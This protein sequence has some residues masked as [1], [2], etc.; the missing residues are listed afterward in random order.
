MS[1]PDQ[2]ASGTGA[3]KSPDA[4]A[5]ARPSYADAVRTTVAPTPKRPAAGQ[6][7]AQPAGCISFLQ[8]GACT[9]EPCKLVHSRTACSCTNVTCKK[10]H[11]HATPTKDAA[12][13]LA[14]A[15]IPAAGAITPADPPRLTPATFAHLQH[16]AAQFSHRF[17][18]YCSTFIP[19][20]WN[21]DNATTQVHKTSKI[22]FDA[23]L[24]G[25]PEDKL[26]AIG[27]LAER[28][29]P[30][31]V[32]YDAHVETCRS[33]MYST[34]LASTSQL[35]AAALDATLMF[36]AEVRCQFAE[37]KAN[38]ERRLKASE[39]MV[40]YRLLERT[41]TTSLLTAPPAKEANRRRSRTKE[42]APP[43]IVAARPLLR[44]PHERARKPP[45]PPTAAPKR[46]K[47]TAAATD[48]AASA[49]S[50]DRPAAT[51]KT[52]GPPTAHI[53][54]ATDAAPTTPAAAATKKK[55]GPVAAPAALPEDAAARQ[56]PALGSRAGATPSAVA[57]KRAAKTT[58]PAAAPAGL[59]EDAAKQLPVSAGPESAAATRELP[60]LG[61]QT[62]CF[63][64]PQETTTTAGAAA[65]DHDAA[66]ALANRGA[67]KVTVQ[68]P[69]DLGISEATDD[70]AVTERR[71]H[72]Q[73]L[74]DARSTRHG[75]KKE[76]HV[77]K[78]GTDSRLA[79]A[80]SIRATATQQRLEAVRTA[81]AADS[82]PTS[83]PP[84]AADICDDTPL[85]PTQRES[86]ADTQ[87][88][89]TTTS[90]A[91]HP[92]TLGL[93]LATAMVT[94]VVAATF[95]AQPADAWLLPTPCLSGLVNTTWPTAN[96]TPLHWALPP[97]A[98]VLDA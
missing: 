59:P 26:P 13:A 61:Q 1:Q 68:P 41:T 84:S 9:R 76:T 88:A 31:P 6:V 56:P 75:V 64:L 42:H 17:C 32:T 23:V 73:L 7:T 43:T 40:A 2:P 82:P 86:G 53:D 55:T 4:A 50:A 54:A 22:F 10:F 47:K 20:E 63:P 52:K 25:T 24:S 95:A 30:I 70:S 67:R 46:G 12:K 80:A 58:A 74:S 51:K 27:E 39:D 16:V 79:Q 44:A 78:A 85:L 36:L 87:V 62:D 8:T 69:L 49:P 45:P 83:V 94:T 5:S 72:P 11:W 93:R 57:P 29:R 34:M 60:Q 28:A 81:A 19:T 38:L 65:E 48:T 35:C 3:T 18:P 66:A 91:A 92:A 98:V 71:V 15:S 96:D 14:H 77:F 21:V 33:N 90:H 37:E 97:G 89:D